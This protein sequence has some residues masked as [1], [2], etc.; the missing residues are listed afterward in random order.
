MFKIRFHIP[1]TLDILWY[2]IIFFW[3]K[4][5]HFAQI[6]SQKISIEVY[7]LHIRVTKSIT[8]NQIIVAEKELDKFE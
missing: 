3:L 6:S 2:I 1:Q 7:L 4:L 8:L 5:R